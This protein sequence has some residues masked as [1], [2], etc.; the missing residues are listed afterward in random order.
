MDKDKEEKSSTKEEAAK[1]IV[2][3][4]TD[5]ETPMHQ[6]VSLIVNLAIA[7]WNMRNINSFFF[8]YKN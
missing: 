8:F 3:C 2:F 6:E 1:E 4:S 7:V 5:S